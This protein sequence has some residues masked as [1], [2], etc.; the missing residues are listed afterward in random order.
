MNID[1]EE[2]RR[3]CAE[4]GVDPLSDTTIDLHRARYELA[5][6]ATFSIVAILDA[7]EAAES[8]VAE[9][10]AAL[11]AANEAADV[12]DEPGALNLVEEINKLVEHRHE[13]ARQNLTMRG[14]VAALEDM[15]RKQAWSEGEREE[16]L[17]A[18]VAALEAQRDSKLR[19]IAAVAHCGGSAGLT[20]GEALIAIRRLT[21]QAMDKSLDI[22][23]QRLLVMDAIAETAP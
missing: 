18:R 12:R 2:L 19:Y 20:E 21:V 6:V 7:L 3:L 9:L 13:L 23:G 4:A 15:A 11:A 5:D 14:R 8:R 22:K 17:L 10:E 16:K 1:R